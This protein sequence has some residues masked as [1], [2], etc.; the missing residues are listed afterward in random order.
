MALPVL[1]YAQSSK[2]FDKSLNWLD[3]NNAHKIVQKENGDYSLMSTAKNNV[4]TLWKPYFVELDG[5]GNILSTIDIAPDSLQGRF[6]DALL[7]GDTIIGVGALFVSE[8]TPW[9]MNISYL[10]QSGNEFEN[11]TMAG[12]CGGSKVALAC[13]LSTNN[14]LFVGGY[15]RLCGNG[16]KLQFLIIDPITKTV[17]LDTIYSNLF[18]PNKLDWLQDIVS[19][20]DGGA[21]LLATIND[22]LTN[23]DIALIKID[24]SGN[25]LWHQI[26]NPTPP[27]VSG[28]SYDIAGHVIL[29]S[30][31]GV[32]MSYTNDKLP[33]TQRKNFIHKLNAQ[34]ETEWI[35]DEYFT[36]G[37]QPS[38]IQLVDGNYIISNGYYRLE[39]SGNYQID[40]EIV[41]LS[42]TGELL[43]RRQFGGSRND[44]IYDAIVQNHDY[45]GK[46]GYVL[47]GRK[48]SGLPSGR[49]DA[50]LV[51]L[52]C[53]G[54][55]TE[56]EALFSHTVL[57][58]SP[59]NVITF[60]NQSQ[61]VY[62][63]S[64]DGGYYRW[65]WGDGTPPFVCGQGYEPCGGSLPSHTYQT[66]GI[67][68]VTLTAI[69][70]N[71]TATYTQYVCAGNYSPGAQAS[72]VAED[73]GGTVFFANTSQN[74]HFD[75]TGISIWDFGDGS[76]PSYETHPHHTY[77]ENG[78]YT[79]TLTVV[80]CA[81]T[82]VY[83]QEV[84]V[85]TVGV[86]EN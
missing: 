8:T 36:G 3:N 40:A 71:D 76:F 60:I 69:V 4:T 78:S 39:T 37:A 48:E 79:V 74:A 13:A 51:R 11:T 12:Y 49:A 86:A 35:V 56:P 15:Q 57:A 32:L 83:S 31:G 55:L 65:N 33:F 29:T 47:C 25:W 5:F 59:P 10:N 7:F 45:S 30:D 84:F 6:F 62:P 73:F 77:A 34:H 68:G 72:F 20:P 38:L 22:D 85:Q 66:P 42:V 18:V 53:M 80:V 58:G 75:Q 81:D 1:P 26:Y 28:F 27:S 23:S 70:C 61:Y 17:L 21:Y 24:S 50:W 64:I 43:W 19:T 67:Y 54:L 46:S 2:Y 82:S 16:Q 14:R 9:S 52:N 63:D 41:K 44:Y